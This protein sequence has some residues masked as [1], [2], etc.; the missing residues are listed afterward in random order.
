MRHIY[1]VYFNTKKE[2]ES[3]RKLVRLLAAKLN[4]KAPEAIVRAV[5]ALNKDME[6]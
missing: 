3:F 6:G 1:S 2:R 4:V 5:K